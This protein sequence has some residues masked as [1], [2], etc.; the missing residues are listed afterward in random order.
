[1]TMVVVEGVARTLDPHFNM[2]KTAEPVVGDWIRRNLGPAGIAA[3]ARDGVMAGLHLMRQLPELAARA[4]ALS[5]DITEAGEKGFRLSPETIEQI[6]RA[7]ARHS[8]WGHAALWV[9]ALLLAIWVFS[10]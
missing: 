10:G 2:W 8:R 6:G 7:E 4:E 5:K 3:D 1:K 9:I